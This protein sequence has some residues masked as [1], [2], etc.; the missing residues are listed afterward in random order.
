MKKEKRLLWLFLAW[1]AIGTSAGC[2]HK[3]AY[4]DIDPNKASSNQNQNSAV[5]AATT[6][7]TAVESPPAVATQPA[8]SPSQTQSFKTPR[9]LDQTKGEIKDLPNYPRA[10]RVSVQMGPNQGVNVFSLVLQ[11]TDPMDMIAAFYQQA[12]KNNKWTVINKSVD[13]EMS[14]WSLEKGKEDSA[15]IQVRK[16]PQTGTMNIFIVRGE[17]LEEASK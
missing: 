13:P 5:Q 15:K 2:R 6:P 3:P 12:I 16:D 4:E 8:P 17:K 11:T 1:V 7:S 14:E 10:R 9:F